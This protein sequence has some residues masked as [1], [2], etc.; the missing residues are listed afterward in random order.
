MAFN[1]GSR[2]IGGEAPVFVVAE[3]SANHGQRKDIA[4]RTIE[5][6]ARAG[7]DA[8]KL[9][10]YTPDTLTLNSHAPPFL[11]RTNNV[12]NGRS[13]YDLYQEAMTP[14]E[15]HAELMEAAE[16]VGLICFS[17]PFDATAVA[18]L[19]SLGAPVHKIASFELTDLP[20]VEHVART[21]KPMILS[22][23]M[24][25]LG[26]IE[27]AVATCREA[28]NEQ[29][30]LLRC[31]ST[32]P[33][34][35]ENMNLESMAVLRSFGTVVGLSDHTRESTV[36]IAATALGAK[37]IEKH[38]ILDRSAG[39]P[40]A[41]FSL[42]PDEFRG[43]VVAVRDAERAMGKPRFGPSPDEVAS[44]TFRRSLFVAMDVQAGD[45]LTCDSVR[46]VRPASGLPARHLPSVLGRTALG[47]I[48]RGTPLEWAMVGPRPSA[49]EVRLRPATAGDA[50][51]LR[52]WRN[53]PHTRAMSLNTSE[54][55]P[56]DHAAWLASSLDSKD[57]LLLLAELDGLTI[58]TVRLDQ[59]GTRQVEIS[60]ALAPEVRGKRL[61]VPL[62]RS[63]ESVVRQNGDTRIVARIKA[64]NEPSI[65]AF[66]GAGYY[67]FTN[68]VRTGLMSCERR[69]TDYS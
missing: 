65:R 5:A 2:S 16:S 8:I 60:L 19:E 38:F 61:A 53:D 51:Q 6:A 27:A 52:A 41:F 58:G 4:L 29:L 20:L 21:G 17:T 11:V 43:M 33:A 32:Y 56:S 34:R 7:A 13:L 68:D 48:S 26:E 42:E 44:T 30:A 50:E 62:L 28:G 55:S 45:V 22:T 15:W 57:R 1:I 25:S 36:A 37:V 24:A 23:G 67:G 63:A 31:V 3:L 59:H 66:K 39:G 54:V 12:W 69:V 35:P 18:F 46:S 40:D 14:W 49:R 47:P 10:T 64:G 9:Q